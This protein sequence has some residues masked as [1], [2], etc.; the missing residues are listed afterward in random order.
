MTRG[1]KPFQFNSLCC[2]G[3]NV[4]LQWTSLFL[5]GHEFSKILCRLRRHVDRDL[6]SFKFLDRFLGHDWLLR[7]IFLFLNNISSLDILLELNLL[8]LSVTTEV[9]SPDDPHDCLIFASFD[10]KWLE[11]QVTCF[12]FLVWFPTILSSF[13]LRLSLNPLDIE[14]GVGSEFERCIGFLQEVLKI[15]SMFKLLWIHWSLW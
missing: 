9:T 13:G 12:A 11:R 8:S 14:R 5:G 7:F 3:I 6:V 15:Q 10:W 1:W 4:V 2:Q